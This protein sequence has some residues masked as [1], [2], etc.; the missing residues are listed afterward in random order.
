MILVLI[1]LVFENYILLWSVVFFEH[2]GS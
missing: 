2:F 1:K